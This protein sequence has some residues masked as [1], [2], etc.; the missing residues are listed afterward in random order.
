M[1]QSKF[2]GHLTSEPDILLVV[3][4]YGY[5]PGTHILV[6]LAIEVPREI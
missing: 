5:R 3:T 6:P 1:F 4:M 2:Q